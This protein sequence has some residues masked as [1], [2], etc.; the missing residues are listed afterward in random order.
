M[1]LSGTGWDTSPPFTDVETY[2]QWFDTLGDFMVEREPQ[3]PWV[4]TLHLRLHERPVTVDAVAD[5]LLQAMVNL[6]HQN[7]DCF[8]D[9]LAN[10]T[11]WASTP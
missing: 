3:H 6:I 4:V 8:G 1:E 7:A 2:V 11:P 9:I 10:G 5:T